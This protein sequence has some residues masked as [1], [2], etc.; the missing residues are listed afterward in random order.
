MKASLRIL[1]LA[2]M[3]CLGQL[4]SAQSLIFYENTRSEAYLVKLNGGGPSQGITDHFIERL[5]AGNNKPSTRTEYILTADESV[6]LTKVNPFQYD[7]NVSLGNIRFSG[8]TQYRGFSMTD[9]LQPSGVKFTLERLNKAGQ[10]VDRFPFEEV[11]LSGASTMI[12]NFRGTDS[13]GLFTE[14]SIRISDKQFIISK[15]NKGNFDRHSFLIDDCYNAVPQLEKIYTD[16]KSIDPNDFEHLP[17]QQANLDELKA[18]L[19]QIGSVDYVTLLGLAQVD[20]IGYLRRFQENTSMA[21]Q[22]SQQIEATRA[23]IPERYYMRGMALLGQAK[24]AAAK[25]DFLES[26]RLSPRFGA[27]NLELARISYREGDIPAAQNKLIYIAKECPADAATQ[28]GLPALANTI[29]LNH[30]GNAEYA[31]QQK[32][33]PAAILALD[34]A[35]QLC[36]ETPIECSPALE[37]QNKL[38]HVG[39]YN[40]KVDSARMFLNQG[41]LEKAEAMALNA[42]GYQKGS[43]QYIAVADDAVAVERDAQNRILQRFLMQANALSNEGKLVAAEEQ[44][45]LAIA[46]QASHSAN[47]PDN[48]PAIAALNKVM[49][50][51]YREDIRQANAAFDAKNHQDAMPLF[52]H[53]LAIESEFP[54]NKLPNLMQLAQANAKPLAL[55]K[56]PNGL[57]LAKANRLAEARLINDDFK[58]LVE[59][60]QIGEDADIVLGAQSLRDA[61]FSQECMNAQAEYDTALSAA[62]AQ[63]TLKRF[64]E[65]DQGFSEALRIA[66]AQAQCEIDVTEANAEKVRISGA[67]KYQELLNTSLAA[68]E[69]AEYK[70]AI[71]QY[72]L[73]TDIFVAKDLAQ[74]FGLAQA[75]LID[76]IQNSGK[77]MFVRYGSDYLTAKGELDGA[78]TLIRKAASMGV[79]QG[80]LKTIMVRLGIALAE[81]DVKQ[82]ISDDPKAKGLEYSQGNKTLKNLAKTYAKQR[83][84]LAK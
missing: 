84:R 56:V 61:I 35:R 79:K 12:A 24:P 70:Y 58:A 27:P 82:G 47:L 76:Y 11:Q 7:V 52:A 9:F 49:E 36:S 66:A 64:I 71:E 21:Q 42:M 3:G 29:Y 69:K 39:I 6:R 10:I 25:A 44:A 2:M 65:A 28:Q 54:V 23:E 83:K 59:Q 53:A 38:A 5:A 33:F 19:N 55:A 17:V 72:N 57:N 51:R 60:Y 14:G 4:A 48:K 41:E 34:A 43:S 75:S 18:R 15:V 45:R 73:A 80:L 74:E 40:S 31:N 63:I 32:K 78:V 37:I 81:R 26:V 62:K 67:V 20:P 8:D 30:M 46:Y 77:N 68:Q 50:L 13:T 1:L 16:F 22:L